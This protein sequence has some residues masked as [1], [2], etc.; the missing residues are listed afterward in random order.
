[1]V[2]D[3]GIALIVLVGGRCGLWCRCG[4]R[5]WCRRRLGEGRRLITAGREEA[6]GKGY[7]VDAVVHSRRVSKGRRGRKARQPRVWYCLAFAYRG[8]LQFLDGEVLPLTVGD[9]IGCLICRGHVE[10]GVLHLTKGYATIV[11]R[12]IIAVGVEVY[13]GHSTQEDS[14]TRVLIIAVECSATDLLHS[15]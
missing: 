5:C 14:D 2:E 8:L 10:D 9:L 3:Q 1:M 13:L 15:W 4:Y 11:E 12:V 6:E 7:A